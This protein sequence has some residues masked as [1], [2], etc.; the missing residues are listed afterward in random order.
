MPTH[1]PFKDSAER[2]ESAR[3]ILIIGCSGSGKSTLARRLSERLGLPH[4]PMDREIFWLPG[5][6]LRPRDEAEE[7]L[8]TLVAGERWIIDGTSPRTLP[9]RLERAELVIW[10]RPSRFVSLRGVLGRWLKYFGRSRPDMAEGCPEKI[11]FEF[12]NY[13]WNFEKTESPQIQEALSAYGPN[14]P[15]LTLRSRRQ[16]DQLLAH[17]PKASHTQKQEV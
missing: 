16:A 9:Q 8:K 15:I 7:I 3:R 6:Q 4:I 11:D 14:V 13:I 5:W 10:L 17:L 1:L 12:L 2:I